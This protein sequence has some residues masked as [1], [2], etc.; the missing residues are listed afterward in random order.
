MEEIW[1]DIKGFEGLY[2]VSSLGNIK[3]IR[4][5]GM[6]NH[7]RKN[8]GHFLL[9]PTQ[10]NNKYYQV[11]LYVGL[12]RFYK[13][14]HRLVA[15]TFIPNTEN[16]KTVNHINGIKTDNRVDNLEWCTAKENT[17]HAMATGL[18]N[19][20]GE[21]STKAL[22]EWDDV[23]D[24]KIIHQ[25]FGL[26]PRKIADKYGVHKDTIRTILNGKHWKSLPINL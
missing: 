2:Q 25:M 13:S 11:V 19:N 12:V 3:S 14:I 21:N 24:I 8:R 23:Y 7:Y 18:M 9:K 4:L 20:K 6:D 17:Q 26:S 16:K 5:S 15:E 10:K 22:L 1:K